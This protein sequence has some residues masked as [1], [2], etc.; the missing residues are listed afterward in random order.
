MVTSIFHFVRFPTGHGLAI[1]TSIS[2]FMWTDAIYRH[3]GMT[4]ILVVIS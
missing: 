3:D 2:M 4:D 1:E